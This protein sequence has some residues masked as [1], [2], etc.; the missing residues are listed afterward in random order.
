MSDDEMDVELLMWDLQRRFKISGL[1]DGETVL[2]L[3]FNDLNQFKTWWLVIDGED[4]GLCTE[5][6]VNTSISTSRWRSEP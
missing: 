1:P 6:P 3:I 4:V 2:C 5:D